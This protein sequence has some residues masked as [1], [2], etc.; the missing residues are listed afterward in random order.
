MGV[1]PIN[2]GFEF[3]AGKRVFITGHTGFKGSWLSTWLQHLGADLTGYALAAPTSPSLFELANVAEGMRTILGDVRDLASLTS[4]LARSEAEIVIHLAAQPLVRASYTDPAT[5]FS[6]NVL[7]TVNLLEAVNRTP[8]VKAVVN[9]TSDKCYLNREWSWPYRESDNLGG[10]DPYSSSKACAELITST[11]RSSFFE[12]RKHPNQTVALASARAGNVIGGGD[13]AEDRLI[14]DILAGF[15]KGCDIKIRHPHAIR[16]WQHVLEPLRGYLILAQGLYEEGAEF[17]EAFNFGPATE[18]ARTVRW[19]VEQ[20]IDLWGENVTW[21]L[22]EA[23]HPYEANHL[24]LD[25]S[26]AAQK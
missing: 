24:R 14:P 17:G 9:V 1:K 25:I 4:A 12:N 10:H 3:W 16:P 15:R 11:Y 22:D 6:T 13:W 7:G 18:D 8:T 21:S 23:A 5:T 19:V 2:K 26:K 20:M